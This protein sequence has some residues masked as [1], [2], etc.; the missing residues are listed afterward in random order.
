[1]GLLS[2]VLCKWHK[3]DPSY[4]MTQYK[5]RDLQG[6]CQKIILVILQPYSSKQNL[7]INSG[8]P[9]NVFYARNGFSVDLLS[10]SD[11]KI[12]VTTILT[13]LTG[14]N[15]GTSYLKAKLFLHF[16]V[17]FWAPWYIFMSCGHNYINL[18]W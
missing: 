11:A 8:L 6:W 14:F 10:L 4:P 5:A 15:F 18:R 1:M 16:W 9:D 2:V 12:M 17:T 3:I 13:W 7:L